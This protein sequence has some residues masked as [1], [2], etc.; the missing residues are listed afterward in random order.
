[1]DRELIKKALECCVDCHT[2]CNSE[3]C[4]LFDKFEYSQCAKQLKK[5]ILTLIN[6]LESGNDTL[7]TNLCEYRKENQQLKDR[8]AEL[9]HKC[10]DCAGCT[11]W[12]CDCANIESHA[13]EQFAEKVAKRLININGIKQILDETLKECLCDN[14]Q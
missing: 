7:H 13:V 3:K 5:D 2:I 10:D 14:N 1:M 9:E 11:Q 6:E 12:K 8:I 4:Y